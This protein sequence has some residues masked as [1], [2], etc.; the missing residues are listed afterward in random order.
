MGWDSFVPS[1]FLPS[2]VC[3]FLSS[4]ADDVWAKQTQGKM[5]TKTQKQ[6]K[7]YIRPLFKLCKAKQVRG[8]VAVAERRVF[9]CVV[10]VRVNVVSVVVEARAAPN[11]RG[12][13]QGNCPQ[14]LSSSS[15]M[16]TC[17][18]PFPPSL[19]WSSRSRTASA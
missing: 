2:D 3:L 6:C 16:T 4:C 8:G 1:F 13:G 9:L 10:R 15:Y 19:E 12:E 5:E 18:P 14:I 17:F 7:D 11:R